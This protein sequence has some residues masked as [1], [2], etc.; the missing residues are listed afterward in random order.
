V[1]KDEVAVAA[2]PACVS[3]LPVV[4]SL[5]RAGRAPLIRSMCVDIEPMSVVFFAIVVG[6]S[7]GADPPAPTR[8]LGK[9]DLTVLQVR[10]C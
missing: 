2:A 10:A 4:F 1:P 8:D 3:G 6:C 5:A 9:P 7:G